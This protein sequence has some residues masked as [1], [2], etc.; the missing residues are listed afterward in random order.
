MRLNATSR[1]LGILVGPAVGSAILLAFGPVYGMLLNT[2]FYLP[3]VLWLVNA[4]YGP[5]FRK[6]AAPPQRAVRGFADIVQAMREI[7]ISR[8]FCP[9]RARC[10]GPI[11]LASA[12]RTEGASYS[13]R[14]A[15]IG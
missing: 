15:R 1:Y 12:V 14:A 5:G 2:V 3:A 10:G 7:A 4:P 6:G 9:Y 11:S 8:P 13:E